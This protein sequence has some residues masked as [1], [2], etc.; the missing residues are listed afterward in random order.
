MQQKIREQ[1]SMPITKHDLVALVKKL[2]PNLDREPRSSL[3]K[4]ICPIISISA[5]PEQNDAPVASSLHEESRRKEGFCSYYEWKYYKETQ[6]QNKS[7]DT[8]KRKE[9]GPSTAGLKVATVN[10]SG[11][12]HSQAKDKNLAR[13]QLLVVVPVGQEEQVF[14]DNVSDL[15][16]IQKDIADHLRL[17]PLFSA[18]AATQAGGISLKTYLVFHERLQ[19]T[20][21]F[22]AHV[23]VWDTLTLANIE[24]PIILGLS[25]LQH[26]NLIL[27][28]D[29]MTIQW[30]DSSSTVTDSIEKLL[31]LESLIQ[32]PT[33]FQVM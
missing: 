31:D 26:H 23:E 8:K 20:D 18:R 12:S 25:W 17:R 28:F 10:E 15:N 22:G 6:C 16:L 7:R 19:I 9:A 2:L 27:N 29:S 24:V 14:V 30:R 1:S 4:R 3:P 11:S 5:Q 13:W 32:I 33:D 21:L